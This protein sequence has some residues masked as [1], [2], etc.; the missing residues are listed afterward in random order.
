MSEL[1]IF[2]DSILKGVMYNGKE[3]KY[4]LCSD[5]KFSVLQRPGFTVRNKAKMGATIDYGMESLQKNKDS[6]NSDTVVLLEYGGN[7][8]NYNWKEISENPQGSFSSNT[9]AEKFVRKYTEAVRFVK[10]LGARVILSTLVPID[11][12]KYLSMITKDLNY[13]NIL[14]W[15]GDA[16]MLY[17]WQEYYNHLVERVAISLG[18]ELLDIR[19]AFLLNHNYADLLCADGIHPTQAGHDLIKDEMKKYL[20]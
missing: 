11:A 10:N 1:Y 7:D 14:S 18:I 20:A 15:L 12:E 5:H 2:G 6:I 13:N 3:N 16:S 4:T 8:S 19:R 17:R 9:P